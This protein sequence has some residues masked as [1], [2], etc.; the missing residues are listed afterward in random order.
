MRNTT[1][2]DT[3]LVIPLKTRLAVLLSDKEALA[4]TQIRYWQ[5]NN[6]D[7]GRAVTH[8]QDGV[9]WVY[10]TWADWKDENFPFWSVPTIR[11][12][13]ARLEKRGLIKTRP[14][15]NIR[16]GK[17]TTICTERLETL[18]ATGELPDQDGP[19]P[20]DHPDQGSVDDQND[21]GSPWTTIKMISLQAIQ[22]LLTENSI[23]A[24]ILRIRRARVRLRRIPLRLPPP[25]SDEDVR[26][27]YSPLARKIMYLT[28]RNSLSAAQCEKLR[29]QVIDVRSPDASALPSPE[30]LYL[31]NAGFQ[32]YVDT[33][34]RRLMEKSAGKIPMRKV[35]EAVCDY[36]RPYV[37]WV[38]YQANNGIPEEYWDDTEQET[39]VDDNS[40]EPVRGGSVFGL[41][42]DSDCRETAT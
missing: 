7:K 38:N 8:F 29:R 3:R 9:W 30:E 35:V 21:Q 25:T 11:R 15:Q 33:R 40:G 42:L 2:P 19:V 24:R 5:D 1:L 22:R 28:R 12:V 41:D 32:T 17:W 10:N 13:W 36:F 20:S 16:R 37:G 39:T 31:R 4:I 6:R 27:P 23:P 26:E 14:H 34:I 18:L